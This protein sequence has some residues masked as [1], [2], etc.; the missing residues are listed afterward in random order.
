LRISQSVIAITINLKNY[1]RFVAAGRVFTV[2]QSA[3]QVI[4]V[5]AWMYI[6]A[7]IVIAQVIF[8]QFE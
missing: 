1:L 2:P 3:H 8:F 5:L 6:I 7:I 4:C